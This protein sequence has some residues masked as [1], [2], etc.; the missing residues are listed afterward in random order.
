MFSH[1]ETPEMA[2]TGVDEQLIHIGT[3]D[4]GFSWSFLCGLKVATT[5]VA[6]SPQ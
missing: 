4:L 1:K 6:S 2:I 5:A 3:G